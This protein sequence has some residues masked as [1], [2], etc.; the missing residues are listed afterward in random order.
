MS[1]GCE[2][3]TQ[4]TNTVYAILIGNGLAMV[5][6]RNSCYA[7]KSGRRL[8]LSTFYAGGSEGVRFG[9]RVFRL[10]MN[11]IYNDIF[12]LAQEAAKSRFD[13]DM[14]VEASKLW[15]DIKLLGIGERSGA[16]TIY[17]LEVVYCGWLVGGTHAGWTR[18]WLVNLLGLLGVSTH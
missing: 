7:E 6:G 12:R 18:W 14:V 2:Y 15:M 8:V 4:N 5:S 3:K 1:D 17:M 10:I 11:Y 9:E 16:D 13:W